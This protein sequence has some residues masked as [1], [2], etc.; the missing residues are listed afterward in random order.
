VATQCDACNVTHGVLRRS[1][2]L[3]HNKKEIRINV[4]GIDLTTSGYGVIFHMIFTS[5]YL[6]LRSGILSVQE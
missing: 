2:V 6:F 5:S 4:P 1:L 3:A